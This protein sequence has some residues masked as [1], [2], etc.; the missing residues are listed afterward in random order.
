MM[1]GVMVTMRR[2]V[3]V[4]ATMKMIVILMSTIG[5]KSVVM[6]MGSGGIDGH[7]GVCGGGGDSDH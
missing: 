7:Y 5:M 1:M 4:M 6:M 2:M 3:V